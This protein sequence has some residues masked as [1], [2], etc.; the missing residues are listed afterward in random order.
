[1]AKPVLW[2]AILIISLLSLCSVAS[3][4]GDVPTECYA[5]YGDSRD[6]HRI[7]EKIVDAIT[8]A[9]PQGVF[10]TGDMVNHGESQKEWGIFNTIT[11][12]LRAHSPLYPVMGNHERNSSWYF[13]S[14]P[15]LHNNSWYTLE[16]KSIYFIVVNSTAGFTPDT[17]QYRWLEEHLKEVQAKKKFIVV[18]LHHPPLTAGMHAKEADLVRPVLSPLFEKY[19]VTMVLSGHDHNYQR[20]LFNNIHYIVTGGGGAELYGQGS[21]HP[22]LKRFEKVY[23]YCMLCIVQGK[24]VFKAYDVNAHLIDEVEKVP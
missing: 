19:A 16:T 3:Y 14:F 23:N 10:H 18:L 20:F 13:K 1:M 2:R 4:A 15:Q 5:I 11:A 12:K 7:H 8:Q 9:N 21:Q 17:D 6:G 24:L 22:F